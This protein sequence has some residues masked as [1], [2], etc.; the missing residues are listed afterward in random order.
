MRVTRRCHLSPQAF[1][2]QLKEGETLDGGVEF[3]VSLGLHP[4]N[5]SP[6]HPQW[7]Y[8]TLALSPHHPLTLSLTP[9]P[10]NPLSLSPH[11]LI[12]PLTLP[13]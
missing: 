9:Y 13:R 11:T 12:T 2:W 6:S 7:G 5:I 10:L 8:H 4:L 3:E 1:L